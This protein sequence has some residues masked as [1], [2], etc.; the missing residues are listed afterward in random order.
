MG[1]ALENGRSVDISSKQM[2]K[3]AE[4]DATLPS[5]LGNGGT[6][7]AT[8][9]RTGRNIPIP[10]FDK[11]QPSIGDAGRS[12]GRVRVKGFENKLRGS[13]NNPAPKAPDSLQG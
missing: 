13:K 1:T 9:F 2:I 6:I 4:L 10:R 7:K 8:D 3:H 5:T 12:I 11:R